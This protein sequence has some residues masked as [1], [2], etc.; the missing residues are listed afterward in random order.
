M[1][2]SG[3]LDKN[4][5]AL[6]FLRI[7]SLAAQSMSREAFHIQTPQPGYEAVLNPNL[8]FSQSI[9]ELKPPI[10]ACA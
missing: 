5:R 8:E 9:A 7:E 10:C 1:D 2:K 6:T 3:L 4:E